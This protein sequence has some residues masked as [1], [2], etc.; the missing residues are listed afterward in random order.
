MRPE[1][2]F[3]VD[4]FLP[5]G[6]VECV[7][8]W[9]HEDIGVAKAATAHASAVQYHHMA[10]GADLEYAVAAQRGSPEIP[11]ELPGAL[12]E[13]LVAKPEPAFYHQ[14]PIAPLREAQ[15]GYTAAE[16]GTDDDVVVRVHDQA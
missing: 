9:L 14:H 15:G 4:G 6:G 2:A 7:L 13:V 10:E 8:S 5:G 16:S 3:P 12:G 1:R 11:P